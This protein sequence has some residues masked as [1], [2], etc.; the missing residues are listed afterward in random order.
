MEHY[1]NRE[2]PGELA[3]GADGAVL[4][5]LGVLGVPQVLRVQC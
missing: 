4:M 1:T 2:V 3:T 5:V